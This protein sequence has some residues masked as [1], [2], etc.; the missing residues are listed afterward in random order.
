MF[1]ATIFSLAVKIS[2]IRVSTFYF[3]KEI[4]NG[5]V[6]MVLFLKQLFSFQVR[7]TFVNC[8]LLEYRSFF[9]KNYRTNKLL[10]NI[11]IQSTF[12]NIGNSLP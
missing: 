11:I 9:L 12:N 1:E 10:H 8:A 5:L 6:F 3:P 2:C 4:N 7:A